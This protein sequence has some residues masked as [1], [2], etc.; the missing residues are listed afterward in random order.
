V[1]MSECSFKG[2]CLPQTVDMRHNAG[3]RK[4]AT[5]NPEF[6]TVNRLSTFLIEFGFCVETRSN[7]QDN[8]SVNK[9]QM[10]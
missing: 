2:T 10:P 7:M 8:L 6:C 1:Q 5:H 3:D 9:T 4:Q